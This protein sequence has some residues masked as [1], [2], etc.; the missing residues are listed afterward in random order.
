MELGV[1]ESGGQQ[2]G[3]CPHLLQG[4]IFSEVLIL[5]WKI[6]FDKPERKT[7]ESVL[8]SHGPDSDVNKKLQRVQSEAL[9]KKES[10]WNSQFHVMRSKDN[11]IVHRNYKEYFDRP[12]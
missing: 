11:G 8:T 2:L 7:Q 4:T 6:F 12:I 3:G 9:L 5:K 1:H 10:R